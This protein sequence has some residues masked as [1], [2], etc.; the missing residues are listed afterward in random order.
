VALALRQVAVDLTLPATAALPWSTMLT[1]WLVVLA[2]TL[3]ACAGT[4]SDAGAPRD[5]AA[6]AEQ[7]SGAS[8]AA[9]DWSVALVGGGQL[10]G[11]D[12]A[13]RDVV[14]WFWAPW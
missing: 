6:P 10:D 13:G 11:G 14:L 5:A 4:G 2:V 9:L 1:R 3:A 12:L 8:L 7:G